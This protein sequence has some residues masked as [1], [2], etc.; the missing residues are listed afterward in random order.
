[1]SVHL[2]YYEGAKKKMRPIQSREEYMKLRHST[3]QQ[4]IMKAVHEGDEELKRKLVQM[5]YSC[6]PNDDGSLNGSRGRN[7]SS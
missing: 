2:I 5:N 3:R 6:L 1:M 7:S 4:K